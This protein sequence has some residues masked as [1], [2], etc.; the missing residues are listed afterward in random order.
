MTA[1]APLRRQ[2]VA[3]ARPWTG[4]LALLAGAIVGASLLELVPPLLVGHVIDHNLTVGRAEGLLAAGALFVAAVAG[5]QALTYAYAY[6]ATVV[7]QNALHALRARVFDH[8]CRLPVSY[9]DGVAVGDT[10]NRCTADLDVVGALFTEGVATLVGQLVPLVFVAAA[11]VALSPALTLVGAV[12]LVPLAALTRFMRRK[13]RAAQRDNRA[14]LGRLAAHLEETLSGVEVVRAFGREETFLVRFRRVVDES[15][16]A[17]CRSNVFNTFYAPLLGIL[18]AVF[19]ALVLALGAQRFLGAAAVPLGDLTAFVL[20]Y[21]RFFA[22]ITALGEQWQRVQA[23]L[24]GAERVF[25]VLALPS[26]EPAAGP[27]AAHGEGIVVRDVTFGYRPAQPVLSSVSFEVRPGEHVALVG[28]TGAGKS[29][30]VNLLGGLYPPWSGTVRVAGVDPRSLTDD[31]RRRLVAVAPQGAPLLTA[32]AWDNVTL[33]DAGAGDAAVERALA[34][35]GLGLVL[36]ALPDG[37][38]TRLAGVGGGPGV[39]LSAGEHQ[40]LALAR[41]LLGEPAVLVLDEATSYV[42]DATDQRARRAIRRAAVERGAALLT[43]VHRL[44]SAREADR[45]VVIE[46]GRIVEDGPPAELAARGGPF[47]ALLSASSPSEPARWRRPG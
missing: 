21:Q 9:H 25:D 28:R 40:L 2:L 31:E 8:L 13:V 43:V 45:V 39:E 41:A 14:A 47:A 18:A 37:A 1:S 7:A 30:L 3:L 38:H 16:A 42:D 10:V 35:A 32:T 12:S 5:A 11:M 24:S 26:E 27:G 29:S 17:F 15:L 23:A 6:H 19:S 4:R 34:L 20:L 46:D 22:P 36:D 44:A 33:G